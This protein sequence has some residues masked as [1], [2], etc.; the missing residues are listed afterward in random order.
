MSAFG[1]VSSR[2]CFQ[3]SPIV[4]PI[5]DMGRMKTPSVHKLERSQSLVKSSQLEFSMGDPVL[6]LF[7]FVMLR[8]SSHLSKPFFFP[9]LKN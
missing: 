5:C 9:Y 8:K 1:W 2:A 7:S 3:Q 6:F 4:V